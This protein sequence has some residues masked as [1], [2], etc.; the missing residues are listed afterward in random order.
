MCAWTRGSSEKHEPQHRPFHL[1]MAFL[2]GK[3]KLQ[4][5]R[6]GIQ[7]LVTRRDWYVETYQACT[8]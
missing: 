7:F 2:A 4:S 6:K 3:E 5:Q 8:M 1:D